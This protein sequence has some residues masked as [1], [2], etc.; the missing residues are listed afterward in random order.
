MY[1][2][3]NMICK[4]NDKN[5]FRI[6]NDNVV[7]LPNPSARDGLEYYYAKTVSSKEEVLEFLDGLSFA[8]KEW[9]VSMAYSLVSSFKENMNKSYQDAIE[10]P[11]FG[12]GFDFICVENIDDIGKWEEDEEF[13]SLLNDEE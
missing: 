10:M 7:I 11:T 8:G 6:T 5:I 9:H 1:M 3:F 4:T 12:L 2:A 13:N